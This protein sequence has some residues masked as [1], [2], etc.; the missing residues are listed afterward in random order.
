ID[1]GAHLSVDALHFVL[2]HQ[3]AFEH[4]AA[5]L[6]DGIVILAHLLH[7]FARAVF[8]GIRHRVAAITIGQHLQNVGA[9]A[10]AHPLEHPIGSGSHGAHIHAVDLFAGNVEGTAALGEV[11]GGRRALDGRPHGVLVVLDDEHH[12]QLPQLGHVEAFVHLALIGGAVAEERH[13]HIAGV[14][15]AVGKGYADPERNIGADNAVSTVEALLFGEHVHRA[16]LALR[17]AVGAAG[18]LRHDPLGIHAARQHVTVV[19]VG[20]DHLIA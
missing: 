19:A 16:A 13:A 9:I 7:L 12:R 6:L 20:G 3:P 11:G 5:N 10:I 4:A 14:S 1:R 15:I 2:A 17:V 8:G 18:E